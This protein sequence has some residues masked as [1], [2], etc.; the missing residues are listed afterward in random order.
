MFFQQKIP[1]KIELPK[2]YISIGV[3][4]SLTAYFLYKLYK[5]K[6][7]Q[8]KTPKKEKG[9]DTLIRINKYNHIIYYTYNNEEYALLLH[10]KEHPTMIDILSTVSPVRA[11]V[12]RDSWEEIPHPE[13]DGETTNEI[14]YPSAPI[15]HNNPTTS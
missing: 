15:Y 10:T 9:K 11:R 1:K 8:K 5:S 3:G 14:N 12:T 7:T 6:N 13:Q 4:I 2:K